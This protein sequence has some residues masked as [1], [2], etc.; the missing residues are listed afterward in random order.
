MSAEQNK[1]VVE[2]F[3]AAMNSGD[4]DAIVNSYHDEGYLWTKGHTLIS[5]RYGK[6]QVQAAAGG[7]YEAFPEGIAFDIL[8]MTAEDDRVAVEATS[9]GKHVSGLLYENEYHFLF[10]LRD[11]KVLALKE[12]MDTERVT[13][14][15]C[16]GQRPA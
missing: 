11:G 5:G 8:H 9:R 3:F 6:A 7:I 15:L 12:Y 2:A 1:Q 13:D 10:H 16:G 14:V 4:V